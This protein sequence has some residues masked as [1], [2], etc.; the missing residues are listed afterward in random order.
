MHY[1]P[2][3]SIITAILAMMFASCDDDKNPA[4]PKEEAFI[5]ISENLLKDGLFYTSESATKEVSVH[6]NVDVTVTTNQPDWC[7]ATLTTPNDKGYSTA[8]IEVKANDTEQERKATVSISGSGITHSIN[9]TQAAKTEEKPEEPVKPEPPVTPSSPAIEFAKSMGMG[10]NLGNQ[11]DAYNN[12][13]AS[14][15]VWG[16]GKAT[17]A[18]FDR[19]AT[20]GIATV[21]IPVTWLGHIGAAPDY[22]IDDAWLDRVGELV[23]YAEKAGLKAIVNIHHDG[24]DGKYWL[25]IKGAA[26]D[27]SINDKVKAQLAAMW[28]QIANKFSDKGEFLIF[29]SLNEIHDGGWGW[30]DNR[31]D[32]GKQYRTLNEWNQTFV[33][34]VRATGGSNATRYLAVPS[35]CTNPDLALLSSF[36]LPKDTTP[37][38]LMVSVHY[39]TPTEF[40]LEDKFSEWGHTGAPGKKA[41]YGDEQTIKDT[42]SKLKN[43]FISKGIPVYIGETGCVHRST[44]RSEA[45]RKYYLEYV[46][47]AAREYDM[48]AIYWD[49][50]SRDA[51]RE[52]SGLLDHA[53]GNY[54]NNGKEIIAVMVKAATS[55][56]PD[57]TLESVY[58]SAP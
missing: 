12:N 31:K 37:D 35:Y 7:T 10:W 34:A 30:G 24:A 9:V 19:L 42:F 33:D 4:P 49:N 45:F 48:P 20:D 28:T 18:L 51:G 54:I 46:C 17:Q 56:D 2:I 15:T 16:N 29:E 6:S 3:L 40:S 26:N 32:G 47:K 8:N 39:Y 55:A 57:Y 13:V 11:M 22:K 5:E 1:Q 25:D 27:K 52:C 14:E 53:N 38:R 21:R 44:D 41:N 36:V 43:R 58:N 50:G 23:D